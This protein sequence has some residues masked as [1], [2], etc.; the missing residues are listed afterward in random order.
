M[1]SIEVPVQA[2]AF[3]QD[4]VALPTKIVVVPD[5]G[6]ADEDVYGIL[7]DA[8]GVRCHNT[9]RAVRE[10][11]NGEGDFLNMFFH[12]ENTAFVSRN[13]FVRVYQKPSA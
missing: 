5:L 4:K 10:N 7:L 3:H 13:S 12:T 9:Y 2:G 8:R 1:P 11:V 6:S